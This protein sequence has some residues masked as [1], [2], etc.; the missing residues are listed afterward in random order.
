VW[1]KSFDDN[2]SDVA[3]DND[4]D[5]ESVHNDDVDVIAPG[6]FQREDTSEQF[7]DFPVAG[8]EFEDG[9]ADGNECEVFKWMHVREVTATQIDGKWEFVCDCGLLEQTCVV[10][11]HIFYVFLACVDQMAHF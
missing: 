6:A 1:S 7:A 9:D 8:A 11:R 4:S 10:C 5:D 2:Q 3:S